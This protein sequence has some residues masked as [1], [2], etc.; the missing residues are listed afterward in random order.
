MD[1]RYDFSGN[2]IGKYCLLE[3]IGNGGFGVV[4]KARDLILEVEKAIKI[5]EVSDPGKA[6]V[7]FS[8]ASIPYKCKH[9]NIIKINGGEIVEFN[10]ELLFI[11]DMDLANG[12]SMEYKLKHERVS[13][14]DS[15]AIIKSIL[16]A[17]EFSHLQGVIH[18]DIKPANI[19]MD[20]SVPKLADFG[21]STALGS[22]IIPWKWYRTHAAPETYVDDSIATVETDI[23][24]T[25]I[26][27]YRMVNGISDWDLVIKSTPNADGLMRSGKLIDKLPVAPYV[28]S[29]VNKVVKTACKSSPADRY[30]SAAEMRNAIEKLSP[31]YNWKIVEEF[32]WKGT[33]DG[34]PEKEIYIEPKRTSVSVVVTNNGRRSS[35]DSAQFEDIRQAAQYFYEYIK[36]TT[37]K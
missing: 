12:K 19:L 3:K 20:N 1:V 10:G 14:I 22:V 11:I 4:Y 26:T 8:E 34:Y 21:L 13:V 33:A 6:S 27:L 24:A 30:H 31:M 17:L 32:W 16:F 18:R 37:L 36:K 35:Q 5:L 29:R 7:L 2:R 25:G 15:L 28:P 9:N 23:Y